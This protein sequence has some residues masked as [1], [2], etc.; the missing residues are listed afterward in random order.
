MPGAGFPSPRTVEP[1][2]PAVGPRGVCEDNP[3]MLHVSSADLVQRGQRLDTPVIPI[4]PLNTRRAQDFP[5][6]REPPPHFQL[7]VRGG[8]NEEKE[9]EKESSSVST[10]PRTPRTSRTATT[11]TTSAE[12]DS[13]GDEEDDKAL[14]L[15]IN[16]DRRIALDR[17]CVESW[18]LRG[19]LEDWR[20]CR[21]EPGGCLTRLQLSTRAIVKADLQ[22]LCAYLSHLPCLRHLTLSANPGL[23]GQVSA[24]TSCEHL[25]QLE[26]NRTFVEGKLTDLL[27]LRR[28]RSLWVM[29]TNISTDPEDKQRFLAALPSC[30]V[31]GP[32]IGDP[33]PSP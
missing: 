26:L 3:P 10:T 16:H 33:E 14:L 7:Q 15:E 31:W 11:A 6:Y 9:E 27:P 2:P 20:G 5:L 4:A 8:V 12:T 13:L 21:T 28:L 18:V 23:G 25:E 17:S 22:D 32:S 19:S 29:G 24:L 1:A 30:A